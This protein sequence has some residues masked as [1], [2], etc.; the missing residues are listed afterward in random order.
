MA[1]RPLPSLPFT[2]KQVRYLRLFLLLVVFSSLVLYAVFRSQR[3]QDAMRRKTERVLSAKLGRRVTI[4]RFDL[5]LL[6]PA[7]AVRDVSIANDRRSLAGPLFSAAEIEI[8]GVPSI[9]SDTIEIPKLRVTSPV[10]VVEVFPDGSTNVD[11]ILAALK[12]GKG[13][14]KDVQIHEAV[15][16][17][18]SLRF[19]EWKAEIDARLKDAALTA[20]AGR[21]LSVTHLTLACRHGSFRLEENE[22]LEF[23][24][25][26]EATLAPGRVHLT[27]LRLR[28]PKIALEASGGVDDLRKPVLA[29][30]AKAATDGETLAKSFGLGLPLE[31]PVK[32]DG[33]IR[34]G[35]PGGL[36]IRAGFD[37]P[38][39]RFAIFPMAGEGTLRLDPRGLLVEVTR[40]SYAGGALEAIVQLDRLD[41]PPLPVKI[42]LRGRGID[43]EQFFADLGLPGTGMM[44]RAGLD[45]TLTFGPGGIEHANGSGRLT[46]A[47]DPGRPSAVKGRSALPVAGGGPIAISDGKMRFDRMPL[48]TAGGA[49]VRLD[50]T[51]A[52][53]SWTPDLSLEA[54]AP[55]LAEIE[56]LA[57]NWYP[58]IQKEPLD[59]PLKLGGSG[60]IAARLT[61]AFSDP[62][63]EARVEA[64]DFV[65][66]GVRFGQA[67]ANVLVD[68]NVATFSPFTASDDGGALTLDG[69]LGFGGALRGHYRLDGLRGD[70][71]AWPLEKVLAFLDFDLPLSGRATGVLPLDGVT[72]ALRGRVPLVLT[73]ASVWGQKVDR[74][75]GVLAFEGDRVA[76]EGA[77]ASL[78]GATA[79][80]GGFYRWGDGAYRFSL[81]ARDV[82]LS[83]LAGLEGEP[84]GGRVSLRASGEGA[85]DAPTLSV[86]GR[87]ADAAYDGRPITRAGR[88]LELHARA[89][90]GRWSVRAEAPDEGVVEFLSPKVDAANGAWKARVELPSLA[91]LAALLGLPPEAAF[92]GRLSAEA[93]LRGGG[94]AADLE[95]EGRVSALSFTAWG[96][97]VTLRGET[98]LKVSGGRLTFDRFALGEIPRPEAPGAPPTSITIAGGV[99]LV[100]P[101]ALDVAAT[102]SFDASLLNPAVDPLKLA[103]RVTLDAHVGGTTAAPSLTGRAVLDSVDVVSPAGGPTF[104]GASG[105]L[106][107]TE[108]K[109]TIFDLGVRYG[110]GTIDF[111]G[112]VGL[113]G[114]R[115]T[116][117]RITA[118][119]N[120]VKASPFEG[121][122]G[123]FSG[124]LL[125]LGDSVP[126]AVRGELAFDRAIYDRDFAIDL[127]ALLQRKRVATVGAAPSTFDP[128]TLDVR[129]VAPPE[130]IEVRTNVAR[131]K[132]SGE[133]FA[134][135]TWGRPLL[136]GE[137]RAEEGGRVTI[138]GQRY[139]LTS[140]RILF[141]NPIRIEPFFEMEARGTISKYQVTFGLTGTAARLSTRFSSDPQLSEAQ[142]ITLMATGDVPST[143]V[144]GGP[145]GPAPT[146]S[147]ESVSKAAR[148]LLASLASDA[149][150]SRTK[151]FFRLDRFQI[152]PSFSTGSTFDAPRITVGKSLG[153]DFNATV[154]FVLSSN[155]QQIITLDYQLSS[156]AYLQARL[157]EYG[158]Y[159]LELRFR[160]RL[161]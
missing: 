132:A 105:T 11:P 156:T 97:T 142:I 130:S 30:V 57:A 91:P 74:L 89:D 114:L 20:R 46:V 45:A 39:S 42:A 28:G 54:S 50:G 38:A 43:F 154:S 134:R 10:A 101:R 59:P 64:S 18:A 79:S 21:T 153:K 6:P 111:G 81:D 49:K 33:S 106:L 2:P 53:G 35:D 115:P 121:F 92:D 90:R 70:F 31:G 73:D 72:P 129:L 126:R 47:A 75:E 5:A 7:F 3:F 116:S 85:L 52:F 58:A 1:R 149:V 103:G 48:A 143:S 124:N 125:L 161:R 84:V 135:G 36:R 22:T 107:F 151:E 138:Q 110:G 69:K 16:Q 150:T 83:R 160:Q 112:T 65:L 147:D 127:A 55:D 15:I 102:G 51:I 95:G 60:R 32:L 63:I 148:E 141:S 108:N 23:A 158:A 131:L 159:I 133:L 100:P 87:V 128:V 66:R 13:G 17:R 122:R 120:R 104:E 8:R 145:V 77:K 119:V 71:R 68:R 109:L 93:D 78:A 12:G 25:G 62:R 76:V 41:R 94:S 88:D 37:L 140:G 27:G 157:D 98:G 96:R 82:P 40:A 139:E 9:T 44:G 117:M 136:F 14:G 80:G 146:S 99:Q 144:T 137:I 155:Q 118:L 86:D 24:L 34:V 123:T 67:S 61:R 113:E 29:L 152:D 4:G 26:A 56:R 19:R